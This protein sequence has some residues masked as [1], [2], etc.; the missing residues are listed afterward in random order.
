MVLRH[1]RLA[2]RV[3][4]VRCPACLPFLSCVTACFMSARLSK[5]HWFTH[6]Q[7]LDILI[8]NA[9][10]TRPLRTMRSSAVVQVAAGVVYEHPQVSCSKQPQLSCKQT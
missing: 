1:S 9:T 3:M 2:E 4:S 8:L 5:V 6:D 7:H 10:Y